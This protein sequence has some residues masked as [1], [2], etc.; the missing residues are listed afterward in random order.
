MENL[1]K[2]RKSRQHRREYDCTPKCHGKLQV[3]RNPLKVIILIYLII[4][5]LSTA[6]EGKV[7]DL[8]INNENKLLESGKPWMLHEGYE[9][10][11]TTLDYERVLISISKNGKEVIRPRGQSKPYAFEYRNAT[12]VSQL[13]LRFRVIDINHTKIQ[14]GNIFQY[15]D[16]RFLSN[17]P[18][19]TPSK[20]TKPDI[21]ASKPTIMPTPTTT[22][23]IPPPPQMEKSHR[24]LAV[25]LII[26]LLFQH[27]LKF[28]K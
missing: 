1:K 22:I 28:R 23:I 19:P 18:T 24:L 3:N 5:I 8:L 14:L 15:S 26:L 20:T 13:I 6:G 16:G 25:I 17:T 4:I 21:I 9:V 2:I 10:T 11:V 7:G 27:L 12:N